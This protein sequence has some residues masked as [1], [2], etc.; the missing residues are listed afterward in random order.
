MTYRSVN[1]LSPLAKSKFLA[2]ALLVV[3]FLVF[4]IAKLFDA[5][6]V[7]WGYLIAF[8]EAAM[9][10]AI[11]DWFAVTALFRRPLG[12]PIPHTAIIPRNKARIA[13][14]L[15]DFICEHFLSTEQVMQK[16]E[17]MQL[18]K[19]TM[20]WLAKKKNA[21]LFSTYAAL[22]AQHSVTALRDV[23]AQ[24]FIQETALHNLRKINIAQVGG[25]VLQLLTHDQRHQ[26]LLNQVLR[27]VSELL[28]QPAMQE[29][30]A[31]KIA[32]EL[33][34]TVY[35]K[36]LSEYLGEWSTKKIINVIAREITAIAEDPHHELRYRFHAHVQTWIY[37][38]QSDPKFKQKMVDIQEQMLENP[39]LQHYVQGLWAQ[40]MDWLEADLQAED[41]VIQDKVAH[42][43]RQV[44]QHILK[45][46]AMQQLLDERLAQIA[47][48]LIEK[49]RVRIAQYIEGRVNAW[50]EGELVYQLEHA[51]GKDLQ[52]IRINGTLVGGAIGLL[53][54]FI[55][56]WL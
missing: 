9:V 53:I 6:A 35:V 19:Q 12:L 11:A 32:V 56:R 25:Q 18:P 37:R 45:D 4:V 36:A 52:Y 15:G 34:N 3:V 24:Q 39:A 29:L 1:R 46:G 47:P 48:P 26:E 41:S 49:Y 28:A 40:M 14:R 17:Q 50:E 22:V 54:H 38:L 51:I 30:L 43:L 27:K 2:T 20:R 13:N 42:G 44:A 55:G 16:L 10:G 8:A 7:G 33:K 23:R 31:E 5:G 21:E